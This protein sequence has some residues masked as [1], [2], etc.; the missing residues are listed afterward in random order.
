VPQSFAECSDWATSA[1]R[2]GNLSF[3]RVPHVIAAIAFAATLCSNVKINRL[4]RA[5]S[6]ARLNL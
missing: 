4:R 5:Q 3:F 2:R 1:A 6:F